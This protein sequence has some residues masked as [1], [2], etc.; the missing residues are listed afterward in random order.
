MRADN[1]AGEGRTQLEDSP[2][3]TNGFQ[4]T[5][6]KLMNLDRGRIL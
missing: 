1:V 5:S 2:E 3:A 6:Q 4:N